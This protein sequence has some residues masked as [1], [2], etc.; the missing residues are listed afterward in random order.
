MVPGFGRSEVVIIYQYIY[1]HIYIYTNIYIYIH[2]NIY[3]YIYI[4]IYIYT[5]I[6][7]YIYIVPQSCTPWIPVASIALHS[8]NQ[9][10]PTA[11]LNL[12]IRLVWE[13]RQVH[14]DERSWFPLSHGFSG[15]NKKINLSCVGCWLFKLRIHH[16][17]IQI[18]IP[19]YK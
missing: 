10:V 4:H 16:N 7:I 9:F 2:T 3:I 8:M 11:A 1:I 18:D 13:P 12:P 5:N 17:R 19:Q 15:E 6:Y 14:K